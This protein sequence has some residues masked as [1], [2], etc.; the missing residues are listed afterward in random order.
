MTTK[1][2]SLENTDIEEN[3]NQKSPASDL[4]LTRCKDFNQSYI[5]SVYLKKEGE[6]KKLHVDDYQDEVP[7]NSELRK[8]CFIHLANGG[9]FYLIAYELY[10]D[11]RVGEIITSASHNTLPVTD[12]EAEKFSGMKASSEKTGDNENAILDKMIKY[13]D[14]FGSNEKSDSSNSKMAEVLAAMSENMNKMQLENMKFQMESSMRMTEI[15]QKIAGNSNNDF[16]KFQNMLEL[17]QSLTGGNNDSVIES[18]L[19]SL[20]PVVAPAVGGLLTQNPEQPPPEN[21]VPIEQGQVK[22]KV[23]T[24]EQQ[25]KEIISQMPETVKQ[26][27]TRKNKENLVKQFH[28]KNPDYSL[29]D[30]TN[31]AE[32][33]LIEKEK[34]KAV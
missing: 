10:D 19:K 29:E 33:I 30:L 11:G 32:L 1:K 7:T 2:N 12:K 34:T 6:K 25:Y 14:L 27:L 17:A 4:F 8:K 31:I 5:I 9:T 20:L 16:E 22:V 24:K 13:K 15:I 26:M 23:K 21:V 3:E 28:E 18:T